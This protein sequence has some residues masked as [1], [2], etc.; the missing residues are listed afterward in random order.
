MNAGQS[1]ALNRALARIVEV[2]QP[3]AIWL[4][5][6]RARGD[7]HDDSDHDLL[8]VVADDAPAER[9]SLDATARVPRDPGVGL[10]IVPCRRTVFERR[11]G[12]VGTLSWL[13]AHEGRLVYCR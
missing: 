8:V 5:G 1:D 3:E 10:D 4:F 12:Q 7:A 13:A 9:R 2:M 6:S 11:K